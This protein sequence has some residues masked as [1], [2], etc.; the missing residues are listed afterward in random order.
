M[1][2][3]LL[4]TIAN[5]I[6]GLSMDAVGQAKSGHL[7][8]PLGGA[9]I[10]TTLYAQILKHNPQAPDWPDRD[11]FILSAGHG[12]MLL[13]AILHMSGYPITLEDI[14]NFRQLGSRTPGHPENTLTPGVE[15]TTGP[16]G[17][18]VGNAVGMALAEAM[19]AARFNTEKHTVVDHQTIALAG[20]G[21]MMEGVS[22]E[23]AS[24][25]GHLGLGKLTVIYDDNRITIDGPTQISFSEDVARR[26][27][28]YGWHIQR[29]D[30]HD[31]AALTT[32]LANART[33]SDKPS[34][35]VA[36]TI[37]GKGGLQYE[38]SHKIHGNPMNEEDTVKA[39]GALDIPEPFHVPE[40]VYTF[41][42]EKRQEWAAEYS[43]WQATYAAWKSENP[44]RAAAW[45]A[46]QHGTLD[47]T[48][49]TLVSFEPG[50]TIATRAAFGKVLNALAERAPF[51]IGGSADLAGSNNTTIEGADT[52]EAGAYGGRTLHFGV[53][54]HAMGAILNG[55]SLHGGIRPYGGTFLVFSDYMRPAIRLAA[56][57]HAAPIYVFTHDSFY[58]GED[59]PTHQ[60][61]EHVA[62]LRAIPNLTVLR[63]ADGPETEEA[64]KLALGQADG[65]VA[66]ILTRQKLT[67]L[68]RSTLAP[69]AGAQRGGYV[70]TDGG[71]EPD[72]ILL[73]AGS[74]VELAVQAA[75]HLE[76]SGRKVRV[77]SLPSHE[78]FLAQDAAYRDTVLP[79]KVRKRVSIEVGSDLSWRRFVGLDGL[80]IC[81][82]RFGAS[83]PAANLAE[84]FGFVPEKVVER[85]EAYLATQDAG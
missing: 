14:R 19:L 85:I 74:E 62:S 13:Y 77:V 56:L 82:D 78:I 42:E 63:P 32:A 80:C 7:G 24:L 23:A 35:I 27:E 12:S 76:R 6:R 15:V 17:Q 69:A 73:A 70:L 50:E 26:F 81:M 29:I 46:G 22:A 39:R 72:L 33:A 41:F 10:A 65:P 16:L 83:A 57:S 4:A 1:D 66:L 55:M 52:V 2:K 38:G 49:E 28:S 40:A 67:N 45:E 36:R 8:L 20:D 37:P 25:A 54:E 71:P 59:G 48:G 30:G 53:R 21:C 31:G 11:R 68:D 75:T 84:H 79:P 60:P 9:E 18:G 5:T 44:K 64:V 51:L 3:T 43:R 61:V 47:L 58:V 34:L